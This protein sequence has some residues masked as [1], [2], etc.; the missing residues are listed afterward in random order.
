[1]TERIGDTKIVQN[2]VIDPPIYTNLDGFANAMQAYRYASADFAKRFLYFPLSSC[3]RFWDERNS[4]VVETYSIQRVFY[5]PVERCKE[6]LVLKDDGHA[7]LEDNIA[8]NSYQNVFKTVK[9]EDYQLGDF[10]KV[11]INSIEKVESKR[12]DRAEENKI[13]G[14]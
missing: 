10:Q 13:K 1:M 3:Y 11:V 14:V 4:A 6:F 2:F 9:L 12:K 8:K 5:T 7:C